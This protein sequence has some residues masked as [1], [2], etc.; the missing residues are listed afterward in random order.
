MNYFDVQTAKLAYQV[1]GKG[2]VNVVVETA[3]G[4][5]SA[6]WWHIGEKLAE[7]YTVLVYDRAGYGTSSSSELART[8]KNIAT[9][10]HQLLTNLKAEKVVLVGHSQGGLYAQQFARL[11]PELTQG[12]ILLD[13]LSASD[14]TFKAL[15]SPEA[16][17]KSGVDKSGT[18]KIGLVLTSLGLG[19]FLKP[20]LR[21]AP[22]FYYH[23][24][25]SK[26]A[27]KYIMH[28]LTRPKQYRA[29]AAEYAL[30]HKE[31]E[32]EELRSRE[33]FPEI[34]LTL[35]TH[36]SKNAIEEIMHYGGMSKEGAEKVENIWQN[37]MK[38]YLN[39]TPYANFVQS[40]KSSHYIHLSD[41]E[42]IES[43]LAE[44]FKPALLK[45]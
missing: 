31:E 17:R 18:F 28:A 34:P 19:F 14:S 12:L 20:M 41:F 5:N 1:F 40:A 30:A 9:E 7:K 16:Y 26:E 23:Q 22:P 11:Y 2:R 10:L 39:F 44:M 38:E 3:V 33:G 8:P 42:L 45:P 21:Q 29:A 13:P 15:L 24:T 27:T 4:S 37:L 43:A 35:I 6:E 25:F 36:T 32:I